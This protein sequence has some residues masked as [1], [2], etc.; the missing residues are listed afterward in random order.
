MEKQHKFDLVR[1][2]QSRKIGHAGKNWTPLF[3][4]DKV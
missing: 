4:P 2:R 3:D 1:V